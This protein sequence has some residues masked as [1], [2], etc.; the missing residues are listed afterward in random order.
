MKRLVY[1]LIILSML[2]FACTISTTPIPPVATVPPVDTVPPVATVPPVDTVQPVDTVAP[3]ATVPSVTTNV[4]C[5]ELSIYLDPALGSGYNCETV[6]ASPEG[7][8]IYPQY[9]KLTLQGYPLSG[10]FF[11]PSISVLPVQGYSDLLPDFVPGQVTNLHILIQGGAIGDTLP[12]LPIFNAAQVF[13][14][15][16]MAFPFASG[17]GIRYLTEYAQFYD[18]VNNNDLFYTYQGLTSD[19]KYW[20]S[21]VLPINNPIL[22][23][24]A[25]TPPG[26]VSWEQFSSNFD[27][28]IADMINQLNAQ[29]SESYTP[30]LAALDALVTSITIQP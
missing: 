21:A 12:F 15:Q 22:P 27:T 3:V 7:I 5:N 30:S 19:D 11:E 2:M 18:P 29:T 26:G 8:E 9:T 25:V 28:Y 4:I 16:Y 14:A 6:S 23:A 1:P 17:H 24:D 10:K 20:V 13:H